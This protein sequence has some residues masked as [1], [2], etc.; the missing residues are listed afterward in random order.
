MRGMRR[1]FL[2]HPSSFRRLL[3][4]FA[5]ARS[6]TRTTAF[7]APHDLHFTTEAR[8]LTADLPGRNRTGNAELEAPS[9]RPFHHGESPSRR[10]GEPASGRMGHGS[11]A[12]SPIRPFAD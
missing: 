5:S 8:C 6:R 9:D 2:F 12:V 4:S 10:T 11:V 1:L 7:E 3:S